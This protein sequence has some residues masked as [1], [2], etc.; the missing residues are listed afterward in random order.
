[1]HDETVAEEYDRK[2]QSPPTGADNKRLEKES[3]DDQTNENANR[4]SRCRVAD[5]PNATLFNLP[6]LSK[7]FV[8][9]SR[10]NL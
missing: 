10:D 3:A 5:L 2:D 7:T 8:F 1:M 9:R 4:P 6:F